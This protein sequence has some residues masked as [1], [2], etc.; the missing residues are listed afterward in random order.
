VAIKLQ[1]LK[2]KGNPMKTKDRH[3]KDNLLVQFRSGAAIGK[4]LKAH[5]RRWKVTTNEAGRRLMILALMG[6]TRDQYDIL[7]DL[8]NGPGVDDFAGACGQALVAIDVYEK[9]AM[10]PRASPPMVDD[11]F[12]FLS[13]WAKDFVNCPAPDEPA[14]TPPATLDP[15]TSMRP[16]KIRRDLNDD[17]PQDASK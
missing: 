2:M 10:K 6:L 13:S 4:Q 9:V 17:A 14:E 3:R 8:E 1:V 11:R 15:T 5:A 16:R 7:T 12:A